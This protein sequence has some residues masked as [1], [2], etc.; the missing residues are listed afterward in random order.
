MVTNTNQTH[1]IGP[2]TNSYVTQAT[3]HVVSGYYTI[4]PHQAPDP[5]QYVQLCAISIVAT[6]TVAIMMKWKVVMTVAMDMKL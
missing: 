3:Y 4:P 2:A 5:Q 6:H 1:K